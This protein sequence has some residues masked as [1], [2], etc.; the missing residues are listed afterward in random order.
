MAR[1]PRR[2]L[3]LTEG[4][5]NVYDAKMAVALIRYRPQ[6]V[7]AVLDSTHTGESLE[8]LVGVG[9]G[10]P[11]VASV[12]EG[13]KYQPTGLCIGIAPAGGALPDAWR[14]TVREAIEAGL[15]IVSGL[16][17]FLGDDP[18][19]AQLAERHGVDIWDIRRVPENILPG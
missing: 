4:Q 6:E 14:V 15:D 5:L 9:R 7:T 2:L 12:A 16:H 8:D 17:A 11:I 3:L 19:L 10:V 1:R 18:E 13:L